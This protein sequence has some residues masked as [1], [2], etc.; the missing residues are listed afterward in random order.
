M[1]QQPN[2]EIRAQDLKPGASGTGPERPWT[3]DRPGE[4]T[5]T[6]QWGPAGFRF[7]NLI[8]DIDLIEKT[9]NLAA[10]LAETGDLPRVRRRLAKYHRVQPGLHGG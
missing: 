8:R 7:A 4:L 10:A 6:R 3:P 2:I 9:K 5:G 1:A